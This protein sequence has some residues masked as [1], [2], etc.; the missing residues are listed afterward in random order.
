MVTKQKLLHNDDSVRHHLC[1]KLSD[2]K[3][4]VGKWTSLEKRERYVEA[5]RGAMMR[6]PKAEWLRIK[7]SF[8]TVQAYCWESSTAG[9]KT[10]I[11]LLPGKASGTPMWYANLSDFCQ[12]RTVY[13]LDALGDAGLSE[14]EQV[15]R[16]NL[17]QARWIAET[18]ESLGLSQVHVIGHSFGGWLSANFASF[19]PH[20][21]ASLILL[22]PV[23]TFQMIKLSII[24]RS[25]PYNMRFLPK[26][27]R[28]GLLKEISGSSVIDTTD[29]VV[30]MIDE[31]ANSYVSGLPAPKMI[32]TQQMHQWRFPVYAAFADNSTVHDSR[33]AMTVAEKNVEIVTARLWPNATHS[34]PM[35]YPKE[36]D[37]EIIQ[38]IEKNEIQRND[39]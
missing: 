35:E 10:P 34:L 15:I 7:T 13:A 39:T 18:L 14:Q 27:W 11:L 33:K 3:Q 16:N 1:A 24:L 23:F 36:L 5:Y 17:D 31:G 29:P 28:R 30:R 26:R 20:K 38:F 8:G 12:N 19:Y 4:S 6:L 37:Y 21:V 32:T 22:E 9:H 25:I 2:M